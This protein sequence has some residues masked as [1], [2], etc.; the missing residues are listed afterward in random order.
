MKKSELALVNLSHRRYRTVR[1]AIVLLV[2]I[3]GHGYQVA[4][5]TKSG[6]SLF[7][8]YQKSVLVSHSVRLEQLTWLEGEWECVDRALRHPPTPEQLYAYA[9]LMKIHHG[10][11]SKTAAF[12]GGY[13]ILAFTRVLPRSPGDDKSK[14]LPISIEFNTDGFMF[15]VPHTDYMKLRRDPRPKPEWF[16]LEHADNK[17]LLLF[18]KK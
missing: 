5:A 1:M 2:V 13:S 12:G 7:D 4:A 6:L 18:L 14:D 16:I 3:L 11:I 8:V 17:D 15:N 10:N 9:Y